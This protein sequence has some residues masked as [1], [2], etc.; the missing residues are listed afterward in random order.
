MASVATEESDSSNTASAPPAGAKKKRA[1]QAKAKARTED[2]SN[3]SSSEDS[4]EYEDNTE[5]LVGRT[6]KAEKII[7][8]NVYWALGLSAI[9]IPLVDA[10]GLLVAQVKML[11]ELAKVYGVEFSENRTRNLVTTLLSTAGG[12]TLNN[13]LIASVFKF[14]PVIGFG[15]SFVSLPLIGGAITMTV[16]NIFMMHFESGGTLLDFDAEKMRDY[17]KEEFEKNKL[18]VKEIHEEKTS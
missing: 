9:P 12:A 3:E 11:R 4:V 14:I 13:A 7:R 17:F 6:E 5:E 8:T 15:L 10:A 2:D 1:K 18:V 16:G